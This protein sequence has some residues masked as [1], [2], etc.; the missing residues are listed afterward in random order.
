MLDLAHAESAPAAP[1]AI[2]APRFG[3]A[4]AFLNKLMFLGYR[5]RNKHRYDEFL[6][7]R[8]DGVPLLVLPTVFNPKLLLTGAFFASQLSV[9]PFPPDAE[10]L[11]M[12][13]GSGV[14]AVFA[15]KYARRVVAVDI[16]SAAVRCASINALMNGLENKL[17]ARHGDLFAPVPAERFDLVLFNPPF[18]RGVPRND[19]DR[20]WRSSD[21][22]ERFAAQL[23][24]HLKPSGCALVLLST[25]GGAADFLGEFRRHGF[26]ITLFAERRFIAE[27]VAIFKLT[28]PQPH[29]P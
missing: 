20:A 4:A 17:E 26:D 7:E 24:A 16:N 21:V 15:A 25:F 12:G 2:R 13:T 14:C 5:F 19:R 28:P 22:P 8:V 10:V 3:R 23:G 9:H 1:A 18:L 29:R 27:T 6:L 11:D